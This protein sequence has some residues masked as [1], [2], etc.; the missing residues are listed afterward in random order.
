MRDVLPHF[1]WLVWGG[2]WL[3]AATGWGQVRFIPLNV[4]Y[5]VFNS[6]KDKEYVEVYVSIPQK[7]LQYRAVDARWVAEFHISIRVGQ[8]QSVVFE[9]DQPF[10]N[11]VEDFS[12]VNV[13]SELRHLF[14]MELP[15]GR[16]NAQIAVSDDH[17]GVKGEYVLELQ[18]VPLSNAQLTLSQIQLAAK[19]SRAEGESFFNKNGLQVVPNPSSVYHIA[20]P[21]LYY[22]AEAHNLAYE[23]DAPGTYTVEAF[24]TDMSGNVVRTF[25]PQKKQKPGKSAVLV[26]GN[27]IV[28]L[29]SAPHFLHL[30]LTDDETGQTVEQKKR[31]TLF[32]PTREQVEQVRAVTTDLMRTYYEKF[33]EEKL[34]EE[35]EI[36]RYLATDEEKKRY[37]D[38]DGIEA[39][40]LFMANFWKSRDPDPTTP[41]NERKLEYF[42]LVEFANAN[43]RTKFREGWRTDRGRVLLTY[44]RPSEVEQSPVEAAARPYEI[45]S[46]NEL[47]GGS[48]FVF[49]DMQGFGDYELMHSTYRKE[50]SQ[51]DWERRVRLIRDNGQ[52][53]LFRGGQP[54]HEPR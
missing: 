9:R 14:A 44:G 23:K 53:N 33:T 28:T 38:L 30:R 22:Y 40:A 43:Y 17:T 49:A 25:P 3:F 52:L 10:Y 12:E 39:K 42:R 36:S 5:A 54:D 50:I 19:I 4:D 48:I 18:V 8:D 21:M 26:G 6:G 32:K 47:E 1:R 24:I 11:A 37:K 35:F 51:P 27:N 41:Q 2:V 46:Y 13:Y 29:P 16:Y 20:M 7:S 34:D 45:W 31:F 15:P